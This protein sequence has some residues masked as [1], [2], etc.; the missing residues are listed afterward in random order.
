MQFIQQF[1]YLK[2]FNQQYGV[3]TVIMVV[4]DAYSTIE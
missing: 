4:K 2:Y 3:T 1:T